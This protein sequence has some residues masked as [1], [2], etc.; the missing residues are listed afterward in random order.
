MDLAIIFDKEN[1]KAVFADTDTDSSFRFSLYND[2]TEYKV[3]AMERKLTE[4]VIPAYYNGLPVTE[5]ADNAFMSCA[6]L[7]KVEIPETVKRVGNNAFYNCR[8]LTKLVGMVNVT[9]IGIMRL[10]CVRNSVT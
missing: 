8:S 1:N 4:A 6:L 3:A 5:V 9:E 2:N 10:Q 7:E